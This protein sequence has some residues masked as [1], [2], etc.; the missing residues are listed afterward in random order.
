M[1]R[2]IGIQ[3][4]C[5]QTVGRPTTRRD[6]T[7]IV[8]AQIRPRSIGAAL[9]LFFLIPCGASCAETTPEAQ[10]PA[11]TATAYAGRVTELFD[12]GIDPATVGYT[13]N[14]VTGLEADRVLR[15]RTQAADGVVRAR[16]VTLTSRE[17][18]SGWL[19]GL[20]P[21]ETLAGAAPI[22]GDIALQV[23]ASDRAGGVLRATEGRLVGM[24]VIAFLRAFAH[25]V[26]ARDLHFHIAPD[27]P[28][29]VSAV[30]ASA[31]L[32]EVH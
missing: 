22:G 4:N 11:R 5:R 19:V 2:F 24:T 29:L 13:A 30:R 23:K 26:D 28:L 14:D 17:S 21:L 12:D 25:D 15:E 18:E 8:S 16:I 6:R 3:G 9:I 27:N 7:P 31:L 20:R 32:E 10:G 1:R